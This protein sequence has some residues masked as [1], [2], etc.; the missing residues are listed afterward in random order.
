MKL[1]KILLILLLAVTVVG[2]NKKDDDGDA[3]FTLSLANLAGTYDLT[4][5]NVSIISVQEVAGIPVTSTVTAVGSVFQVE[6][7]FTENGTYS[8][9]GQYLLTTTVT[10]GSKTETDEEIFVINENGTFTLDANS[11]TIE[12]SGAGELGNGTLDVSLFNE[13]ELRLTQEESIDTDDI[14]SD[15]MSEYRFVRQ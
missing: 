5:L 8:A 4:F 1:S 14:M 10:V 9:E 6:V 12:M 3:G 15:I 13:N 7:I 11:E 2:C